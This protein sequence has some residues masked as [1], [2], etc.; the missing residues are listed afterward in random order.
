MVST[1]NKKG[2]QFNNLTLWSFSKKYHTKNVLRFDV[3]IIGG[4][5]I[6]HVQI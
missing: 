6:F 1:R 4:I 3:W 5:I 2:N